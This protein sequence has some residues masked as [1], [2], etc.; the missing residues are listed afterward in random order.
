MFFVS[1]IWQPPC[2]SFYVLGRASMSLKPGRVALCSRCPVES[3]GTAFLITQLGHSRCAPPRVGCVYLPVVVS[4]NCCW[5]I[6]GRYLPPG[7]SAARTGCDHQPLWRISC[8]GTQPTEQDLLQQG[9]G[10]WWVLPL[11][12]SLVEVVGWWC[13]NVVWSCPLGALAPQPSG[14]C[15][16]RSTT[17]CVL[18]KATWHELQSSLLMAAIVLGLEVLRRGQAMNQGWLLLLLGWGPLSVRSGAYWGQIL[19]AWEILGKSKAWAKIGHLYGKVTGN[20]MGEPTNWMGQCLP[21]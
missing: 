9:S 17:T 12:V 15:R 10:A 6:S 21:G 4:L 19:L 7:Q 20:S 5:H 14:R 13:F 1:S 11:S 18:L 2:V 8:A 3:S 16:P